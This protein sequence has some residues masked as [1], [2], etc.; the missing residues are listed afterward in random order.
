MTELPFSPP[1]T[2]EQVKNLNDFQKNGVMHPFTCP[3]EHKE[4]AAQ[5]EL[6]AT[7]DGW[8]C[9]CGKYTQ[10]W[11]HPFMFKSQEEIDVLKGLVRL[12]SG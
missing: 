10:N 2:D 3:G 11:A 4:C 8:V 6:I 1:W 9:A 12:F 5:R 7:N